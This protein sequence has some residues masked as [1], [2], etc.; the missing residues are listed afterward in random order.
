MRTAGAL[1]T[2]VLCLVALHANATDAA[3]GTVFAHV[4][5]GF[6]SAPLP[7]TF[8]RLDDAPPPSAAGVP[9]KYAAQTATMRNAALE[10]DTRCGAQFNISGYTT[11]SYF[12][13]ARDATIR[14]WQKVTEGPCARGAPNDAS[15]RSQG[16]LNNA[17]RLALLTNGLTGPDFQKL[18]VIVINYN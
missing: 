7:I 14:L 9:D 16:M 10:I 4:V 18:V 12:I 8:R 1:S 15:S 2:A 11:S 17:D 5:P 3:L 6:S 13:Y